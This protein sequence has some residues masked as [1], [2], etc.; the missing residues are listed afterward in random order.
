[1][2][3]LPTLSES[4]QL[5]VVRHRRAGLRRT[6]TEVEEAAAAALAGRPDEWRANLTPHLE[7]LQM[8]WASHVRGTEGPDGLWEQ[9]RTDAPRLQ[10]KLRRLGSAHEA[11][12]AEIATLRQTLTDACDDESRLSNVRERVTALLLQ[13]TRH[14]QHG[15]D[16]IYEAYDRDVGGNG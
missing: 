2:P 9:I 7:S 1:M 3:G 8:A 16:L 6:M 5:Q 12:G 13:L 11:L 15:A 4:P 14:R 10:G